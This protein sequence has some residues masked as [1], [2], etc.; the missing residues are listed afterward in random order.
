MGYKIAYFYYNF[1]P[2]I[3]GASVHGYNLAKELHQLGNRLYKVNGQSDPFTT[4]YPK[5]LFGIIKV[6]LI[7]DIVY[8]RIDFLRKFRNLIPFIAKFFFIKKVVV[9]LNCPSDELLIRNNLKASVKILDV[10]Y[11]WYLRFMD[12]VIVVSYPLKKYAIKALKLKNVAV[13]ENGGEKFNVNPEK[14]R[15]FIVNEVENLKSQNRNIIVWASSVDKMNNMYEI[16]RLARLCNDDTSIITILKENSENIN[17]EQ[18][19]KLILYKNLLRDEVGYIIQNAQFGIAL[20]NE[21]PWSRWGFYNSSLKVYEYLAN[22]LKVFTNIKTMKDPNLIKID[23]IREIPDHINI[24]HS[25]Q[26]KSLNH[27]RSWKNVALETNEIFES[28]MQN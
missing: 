9:E 11:S 4:K 14:I 2:I 28:V 15:K 8:V 25:S 16:A 24:T 20:Y 21:Y 19:S 6:I 18:S 3:G 23:N 7:S 13:I 22:G 10:L 17:I 26:V 12:K 27:Y 5:S 1:Y